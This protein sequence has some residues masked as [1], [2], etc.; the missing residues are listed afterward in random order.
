MKTTRKMICLGPAGAF[1]HQAAVWFSREL[2]LS[3][4]FCFQN[5]NEDILPAIASDPEAVG[6]IA[7]ENTTAGF[8]LP[9]VQAWRE[10]YSVK[11]LPLKAGGERWLP[12][13]HHLQVKP[14]SDL[15]KITVVMSHRQALAQCQRFISKS[16]WPTREVASTALAAAMAANDQSGQT[17]AIASVLAADLYGL[18]IAERNIQDNAKNRTHFILIGRTSPPPTGSDRTI[19][20][21]CLPNVAGA[22]FRLLEPFAS[23]NINLSHITSITEGDG[24]RPSLFYT[25]ID[26]HLDSHPELAVKLKELTTELVVLGSFPKAD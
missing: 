22:L 4:D 10:H 23:R 25:E 16:G 14:G 21:F 6:V 11:G 20:M 9:V 19:V 1:S 12:I 7:V 18:H 5:K 13:A 2:G 26:C 24:E 3:L 17:A 8:V 15:D